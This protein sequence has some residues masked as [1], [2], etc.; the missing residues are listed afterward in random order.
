MI[1][2]TKNRRCGYCFH[3]IHGGE[4]WCHNKECSKCGD[5][6]NDSETM[7]LTDAEAEAFIFAEKV[8]QI[9]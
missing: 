6:L 8:N 9:P 3:R 7:L 4:F 1:T 5:L 2:P